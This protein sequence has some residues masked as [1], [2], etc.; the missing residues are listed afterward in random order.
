MSIRALFKEQEGN[1][2]ISLGFFGL[3]VER[4]FVGLGH[5][6]YSPSMLAARSVEEARAR[7]L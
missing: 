2:E 3:K 4:G 6:L 5:I 7:R 1:I